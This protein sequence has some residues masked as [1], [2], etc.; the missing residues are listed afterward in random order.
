M[1]KRVAMLAIVVE[2]NERTEELN[3]V[4]HEYSEYIIGRLGLPYRDRS[5]SLISIAIDGPADAISALSGKLG[6]IPGVSAKAVY[7]KLPEDA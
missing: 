6:Q 2:D 7:A 5:I 4:L 3:H 1:E